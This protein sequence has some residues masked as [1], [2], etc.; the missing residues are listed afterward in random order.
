MERAPSEPPRP[1]L[2]DEQ[3]RNMYRRLCT[4]TV[5]VE[6]HTVV[7]RLRNPFRRA[8]AESESDS[9]SDPQSAADEPGPGLTRDQMADMYDR[10]T[11]T[12]TEVPGYEYTIEGGS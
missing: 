7:T 11:E 9:H 4:T 6:G 10:L 8:I 3:A 2:T 12:V 1:G 5:R